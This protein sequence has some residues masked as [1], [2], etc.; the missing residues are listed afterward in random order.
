M[1]YLKIDDGTTW[2]VDDGAESVQWRLRYGNSVSRT[3]ALRAA[4]ILSAYSYLI[5]EQSISAKTALNKLRMLRRAVK[6]AAVS[7]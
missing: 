5:G 1:R 2:P 4:S 6:K 3:D 7:E